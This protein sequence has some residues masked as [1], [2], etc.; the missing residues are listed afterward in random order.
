[1]GRFHI[2]CPCPP[3]KSVQNPVLAPPIV[4]RASFSPKTVYSS[5][6]RPRPSS[7][8]LPFSK[9]QNKTYLHHNQAENRR[10]ERGVGQHHPLRAQTE[11]FRNVRRSGV[12]FRL[13]GSFCSFCPP[14][15]ASH[16]LT[17]SSRP[18]AGP[19]LLKCPLSSL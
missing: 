11:N 12:R 18:K 4:V 19:L 6:P 2:I 8:R 16:H 13:A 10:K 17:H 7:P 9:S 5:V 1:M 14:W 3:Y 15:T